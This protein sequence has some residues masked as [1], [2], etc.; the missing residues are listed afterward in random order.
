M[1]A[2]LPYVAHPDA[3]LNEVASDMATQKLGSAII[4][5]DGKLVG[6]FTA[7]DACR[8]LSEIFNKNQKTSSQTK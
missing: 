8:A 5:E 3:P 6:I 1:C 4:L 2:N 7:T